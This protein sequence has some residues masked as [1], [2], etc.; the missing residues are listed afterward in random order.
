MS[1]VN[2]FGSYEYNNF[3]ISGQPVQFSNELPSW[4]PVE[5][6]LDYFKNGNT[7]RI[8]SYNGLIVDSSYAYNGGTM[9]R[10]DNRNNTYDRAEYTL[11]GETLDKVWINS[12]QGSLDDQ[13]MWLD[14]N[15]GNFFSVS[16]STVPYPIRIQPVYN[17]QGTP[18]R[19]DKLYPTQPFRILNDKGECLHVFYNQFTN[20]IFA[21]IEDQPKLNSCTIFFALRQDPT[22]SATSV[23][24]TAY[25]EMLKNLFGLP[26]QPLWESAHP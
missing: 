19:Q 4:Y 7:V 9:T 3:A 24:G 13:S 20:S 21:P 5:Q 23:A 16:P 2:S 10:L 11:F 6:T 22:S 12:G 1:F 15:V 17:T 8:Y 18:F 26:P 14:K 25:V